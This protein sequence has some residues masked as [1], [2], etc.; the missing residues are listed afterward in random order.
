MHVYEEK[1]KHIQTRNFFYYFF[2][3]IKMS[4][5]YYLCCFCP[6]YMERE[7]ERI[8]SFYLYIYRLLVS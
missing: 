1:K 8:Y 2:L 4:T 6:I 3:N 5:L 7:R